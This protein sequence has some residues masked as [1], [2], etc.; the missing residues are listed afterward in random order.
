MKFFSEDLSKNKPLYVFHNS[1]YVRAPLAGG[2]PSGP[3]RHWNNA[4]EFCDPRDIPF[5]VKPL[6]A[7]PCE[8]TKF[9]EWPVR[10]NPKSYLRFQPRLYYEFRNDVSN[11]ETFPRGWNHH[12]FRLHGF[13][14]RGP[15]F[16]NGGR[17][18][19]KL[20][21]NSVARGNACKVVWK[22][23]RG[24]R[25]AC[26]TMRRSKGLD[27]G[28]YQGSKLY[29]GVMVFRHTDVIVNGRELY[30]ERPRVVHV[31]ESRL[32]ANR[33]VL[34]L[35]FSVP[36]GYRTAD[37]PVTIEPTTAGLPVTAKCRIPPHNET[38]L[39]CEFALPAGA[40]GIKRI[41]IPRDITR[42]YRTNLSVTLWAKS[43]PRLE[44]VR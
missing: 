6:A 30:P 44:F 40:A 14:A 19:F 5:T 17:G 9:F 1:W 15:I 24:R 22:N 28:A 26:I 34:S 18:Q 8:P 13:R 32:A 3:L 11:H 21:P 36:I 31:A 33:V 12:G 38:V 37:I 16:V 29:R 25:L 27:V 10:D 35:S 2:G 20:R 23:K 43:D 39:I 4:I 41:L 7:K 42:K